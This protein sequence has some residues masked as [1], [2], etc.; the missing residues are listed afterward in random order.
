MSPG[1]NS[2]AFLKYKAGSCPAN[3]AELVKIATKIGIQI[4]IKSLLS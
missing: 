3:A 2:K 1:C 4:R